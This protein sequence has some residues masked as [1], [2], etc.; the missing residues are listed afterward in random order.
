M[1]SVLLIRP[2]A[3]LAPTNTSTSV[4]I[5]GSWELAGA[6]G[7]RTVTGTAGSTPISNAA[8]DTLIQNATYI[9]SRGYFELS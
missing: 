8:A 3:L 6:T 2:S 4:L 5:V 9:A 7:A 1:Q